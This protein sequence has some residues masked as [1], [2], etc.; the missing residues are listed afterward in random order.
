MGIVGWCGLG[1]LKDLFPH[2]ISKLKKSDYSLNCF[3][4]IPFLILQGKGPKENNV[5]MSVFIFA[6]SWT[7]NYYN[8]GLQQMFYFS[9]KSLVSETTHIGLIS[10]TVP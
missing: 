7:Q 8:W 6:H 5:S 1:G 10:I 3:S 2:C 9:K 4:W